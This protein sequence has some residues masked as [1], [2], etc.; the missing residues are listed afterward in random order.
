MNEFPGHQSVDGQG[1][2]LHIIFMYH[3]LHCPLPHTMQCLAKE[4]F[5]I[6]DRRECREASPKKDLPSTLVCIE[7][8]GEGCL[9]VKPCGFHK[10]FERLGRRAI[11]QSKP[12]LLSRFGGISVLKNQ[13]SFCVSLARSSSFSMTATMFYVGCYTRVEG[14]VPGGKGEGATIGMMSDNGDL[15]RVTLKPKEGTSSCNQP[16]VNP[17]YLCCGP[18]PDVIYVV[19]ETGDK[20]GDS[21]LALQ[22]Q[23]DA[24]KKGGSYEIV[25]SI[26]SGGGLAN[27]YITCC[28]TCAVGR[29]FL[30]VAGYCSGTMT[31]IEVDSATG[32]FKGNAPLQVVKFTGTGP[33]KERQEASHA[34]HV[35][36]SPG[37]GWVLVC[38]LGSDKVWSVN[39][40][41]LITD[42]H[43]PTE[44]ELKE[45]ALTCPP[46]CGP[47]HLVF[48]PK[49]PQ[50]FFVVCELN[51]TVLR[52]Q[53]DE[54]SGKAAILDEV[55]CV[56][57]RSQ[58]LQKENG[59]RVCMPSAIVIHPNAGTLFVGNRF[60][61]NIGVLQP[62]DNANADGKLR[63][64]GEFPC[65][66]ATPRDICLAPC[67]NRL[68]VANQD[69]DSISSV[70][71][72]SWLKLAVAAVGS[73]SKEEF[74]KEA[75]D[76]ATPTCV[77]WPSPSCICF[78]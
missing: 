33:N 16:I 3:E 8:L 7:S 42:G 48:H 15:H 30:F 19:Q 54:E 34:H 41:K 14:H 67:G 57:E 56:S 71:I 75:S 9:S 50:I 2:R 78:A 63:F 22:V 69:S 58:Q 20:E 31:L 64:I 4:F 23:V 39:F 70:D 44:E 26:T 65:G 38:D 11:F 59:N 68:L 24:D 17:S 66:G 55:S 1:S 13:L 6:E 52:C 37:C 5:R 35:A 77:E 32:G 62:G 47:R 45:T 72:T 28:R 43:P 73:A 40:E 18:V 76:M 27:C 10:G 25:D 12:V 21:V 29:D 51:A 46:G 36:V 53:L 60:V 74:Q 61:D 49:N